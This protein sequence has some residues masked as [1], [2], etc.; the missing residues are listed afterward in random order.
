[1]LYHTVTCC[2]VGDPR[3]TGLLVIY[4][5]TCYLFMPKLLHEVMYNGITYSLVSVLDILQSKQSNR[6]HHKNSQEHNRKKW[7]IAT[8]NFLLYSIDLI[9]T[10]FCIMHTSQQHECIKQ[11]WSHSYQFTNTCYAINC[12][13]LETKSNYSPLLHTINIYQHKE[14]T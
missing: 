7:K 12:K 2:A 9:I 14:T 11:A 1:M 6:I 5:N 3:P 8:Q 4:S 13:V 10:W